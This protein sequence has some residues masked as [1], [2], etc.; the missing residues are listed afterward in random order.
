MAAGRIKQEAGKMAGGGAMLLN[1]KVDFEVVQYY[2]GIYAFAA[3]FVKGKVVLDVACGAGYGSS[4][5]FS[6]GARAVIGG[7]ITAEAIEAAQKFYGGEGVEFRVL[8]ATRLP[9]ADESFDVVTSMETIEHLEQYRDYLNECKRVLKEGGVFVCSTP[10]KGHGIPEIKE[11]SPFHVHEFYA[12][13]FKE[14]L[15]QFFTG[16]Q[17]YGHGYWREAEKTGWRIR[18]RIEKAITPLLRSIPKLYEAARYLDR[19]LIKRIHYTQLNQI[20]DLE[21]VLAGKEKPFVLVNGSPVPKTIIAVA[22]KHG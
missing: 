15:S 4:Y 20:V 10:N 8:D 19:I 1:A 5:L 6:K 13:E 12:E 16:T 21:E 2:L 3:E 18:I 7:D 11:F 17:L 14:L 22:R 9:F